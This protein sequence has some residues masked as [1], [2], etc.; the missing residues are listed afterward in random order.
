MAD[1]PHDPGLQA[2]RTELAW[3]RTQLSLLVITCLALRDQELAVTLLALGSAALL[4]LGQRR[5]YRH[6]LAMLRDERGRAQLLPVLGTS[7][8]LLVMALLA[9]HGALLR[10]APP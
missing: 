5:R 7:L 10:V 6:S 2:E 8:A 4:W 1:Q 3:R 9:I